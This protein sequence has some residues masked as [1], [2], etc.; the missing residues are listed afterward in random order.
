MRRPAPGESATVACGGGGQC[1][2]RLEVG[3][4]SRSRAVEVAGVGGGLRSRAAEDVV[5]VELLQMGR[6][7]ERE[8]AWHDVDE[9]KGCPNKIRLWG[10]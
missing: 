7:D 3:E 9:T 4:G 8:D 2:C 5:G 6:E 10:A 1:R